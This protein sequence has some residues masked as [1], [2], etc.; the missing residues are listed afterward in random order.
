[1]RDRILP[2]ATVVAAVLP[3]LGAPA[4]SAQGP[5]AR[6]E[7]DYPIDPETAP[8]PVGRAFE[9]TTPIEVDGRLDEAG[10]DVAEPMNNFI[11]SVPDAGWPATEQT[12]VRVLYDDEKLYIGALCHHSRPEDLVV[13]TLE[14]EIPGL[15]SHEIDVFN[16][17]LDPFLDRRNSYTWIINPGGAYRDGQTFDDSRNLDYGWDGI[18]EL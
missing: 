17:Y 9:A 1:M 4:A 12:V 15:S 7:A 16:V 10:W 13:K 2:L 11:Q 5:A 14:W 8:R 18:V 6:A 3:L